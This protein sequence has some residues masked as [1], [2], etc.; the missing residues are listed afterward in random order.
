M[1]ESPSVGAVMHLPTPGGEK[2]KHGVALKKK[3][4]KENA[5]VDQATGLPQNASASSPCPSGKTPSVGSAT[6][7][8]TTAPSLDAASTTKETEAVALGDSQTEAAKKKG[9]RFFRRLKNNKAS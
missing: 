9:F 3:G 2:R 1:P 5:L 4:R 8:N 7:P 6:Q